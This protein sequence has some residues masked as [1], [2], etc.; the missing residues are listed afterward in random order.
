MDSKKCAYNCVADLNNPHN[1][2]STVRRPQAGTV[3]GGQWGG[4]YRRRR[5]VG[6]WEISGRYRRRWPVG[7]L[8]PSTVGRPQAR[9][10]EA[11][12][13]AICLY[14]NNMDSNGIKLFRISH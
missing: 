10:V 2:Q 11:S 4:W 13:V 3:D 9:T 12:T 7:R 6:N 1:P 5:P 8:A 14:N